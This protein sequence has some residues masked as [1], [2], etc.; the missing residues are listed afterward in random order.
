[1][2]TALAGTSQS[3]PNFWLDPKNGVS[4]GIVSQTPE[5]R[6][7]S[8]E[9]LLSLPVTGSQ[10]WQSQVLGAL[11]SFSRNRQPQW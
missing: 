3:A 9:A 8:L 7:N 6:L 11:G 1:M 4:Y 2:G 5:Y 10:W